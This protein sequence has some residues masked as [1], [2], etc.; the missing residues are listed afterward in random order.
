MIPAAIA[1]AI[2]SRGLRPWPPG[3]FV[4]DP[5]HPPRPAMLERALFDAL[6]LLGRLAHRLGLLSLAS[7]CYGRADELMVSGRAYRKRRRRT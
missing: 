2:T 6:H 3:V 5:A 4:G 7:A 1:A